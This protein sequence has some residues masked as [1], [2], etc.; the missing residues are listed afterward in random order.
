M[1][2]WHTWQTGMKPYLDIARRKRFL[3]WLGE[4]TVGSFPAPPS[5]RALPSLSYYLVICCQLEPIY[6]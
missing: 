1:T 6:P 2:T 4:M 5:T 3:Y